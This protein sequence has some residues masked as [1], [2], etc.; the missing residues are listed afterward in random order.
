MLSL[1]SNFTGEVVKVIQ[2]FP[3][4]FYDRARGGL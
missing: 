4:D 1:M 3:M 2:W